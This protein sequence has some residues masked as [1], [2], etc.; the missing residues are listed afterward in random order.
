[1]ILEMR[2]SLTY[3]LQLEKGTIVL[4]W[5]S[6]NMSSTWGSHDSVNAEITEATC[7]HIRNNDCVHVDF[8][9]HGFPNRK[10]IFL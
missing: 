6:Q 8:T 5:I 4:V 2:N 3:L 10:S 7:R 1:M 9:E